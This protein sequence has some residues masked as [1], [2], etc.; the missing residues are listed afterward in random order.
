METLK[1]LWKIPIGLVEIYHDEISVVKNVAY[2]GSPAVA[3]ANH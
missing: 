2:N 3:L 1:W